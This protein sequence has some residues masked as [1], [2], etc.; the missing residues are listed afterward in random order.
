MNDQL[1]LHETFS[2]LSSFKLAAGFLRNENRYLVSAHH[3]S[4][5]MLS[6]SIQVDDRTAANAAVW[7]VFE[8]L[9]LLSD[10]RLSSSKVL[11]FTIPLLWDAIQQFYKSKYLC[12][13]QTQCDKA[14][15][16]KRRMLAAQVWLV[17]GCF[18]VYILAINGCDCVAFCSYFA[19]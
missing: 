2:S 17:T 16:A 7:S 4:L 11:N 1:H 8:G 5:S 3:L 9:K 6:V 18:Q 14:A 13:N 19:F 10:Q 12:P 15:S